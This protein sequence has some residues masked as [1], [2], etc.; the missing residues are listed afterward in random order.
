[1][2]H[3]S[4]MWMNISMDGRNNYKS[5]KAYAPDSITTYQVSGFALSPTLGLGVIKQPIEFIVRQP[6]YLVA[7]LPYS[8]KRGEVAL[9]QVTI[10]N[11]LGNTVTTDVTLFN[12]NNEVEFVET[13]SNDR[14][15]LHGFNAKAVSIR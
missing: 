12:K 15:Y 14:M 5:H 3:E 2:F 6:F 13:S 4:W 11:F 8:I 10:F 1:M 7:N 9:I